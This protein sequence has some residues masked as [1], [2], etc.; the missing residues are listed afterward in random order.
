MVSRAYFLINVHILDFCQ[1]SCAILQNTCSVIHTLYELGREGVPRQVATKA[2]IL[3]I[4]EAKRSSRASRY[5]GR[6]V[7]PTAQPSYIDSSEAYSPRRRNAVIATAS[8]ATG[9]RATV[10]STR[11]VRPKSQSRVF[12]RTSAP[13]DARADVN[14]RGIA[15]S[16]AGVGS[17][18]GSRA[19]AGSRARAEART[20]TRTSSR[21]SETLAAETSASSKAARITKAEAR[22]RAK[23][24]KRADKKFNKQ[25]GA[26]EEARNL[27]AAN[28]VANAA[29]SS[30][31]S[32]GAATSRAAV[33]KGQMGAS[34]KK[35]SR[36]QQNAAFAASAA[37]KVR[38]ASATGV[39]AVFEKITGST[40]AIVGVA[41]AAC[42]VFTCVFLYPT[43][44]TYYQTVRENDRLQAE[45]DALVE[46][47]DQLEASVSSLQSTAGIEARAHDQLGWVKSGEKSVSVNGLDAS[48][49]S[50][51][52]STSLV[53]AVDTNEI[54][55][56]SK[57]YSPL[58]D[59]VF[60]V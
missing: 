51:S 40:K 23:A 28:N 17:A 46:R 55:Y 27:A 14:A 41:A 47:N 1:S 45:Y 32:R 12:A 34:Q 25:F 19:G 5:S 50:S 56:P 6:S 24:K 39:S 57:W 26:L 52:S 20:S 22:K 13:A 53:A 3:S 4:D 9:A 54:D 36:M 43:A 2:H 8:T 33:Y 60:G 11:S 21:A 59:L 7:R 48:V 37:G 16:H 38:A 29:A 58:L 35:A 49:D 15:G 18:A 10:R 44:Q 30:N 31:D 42:L